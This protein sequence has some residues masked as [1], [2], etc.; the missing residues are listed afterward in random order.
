[1][2]MLIR[3][4]VLALAAFGGK[5]IYDKLAPRKNSLRATGTEFA[6]RTGDAARQVGAELSDSTQRVAA[7]AKEQAGEVKAAAEDA[8]Y[9][10]VRELQDDNAP[11]DPLG[12]APA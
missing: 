3:L 1:M 12:S 7:S 11:S 10:A 2:R 8:K 6:R 5:T 4:A 9:E